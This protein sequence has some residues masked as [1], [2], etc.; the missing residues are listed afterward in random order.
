[1]DDTEVFQVFFPIAIEPPPRR[2]ALDAA[3]LLFIVKPNCPISCKDAIRAMLASW[4]ISLEELPWYLAGHFGKEAIQNAV[5]EL[6]QE[7]LSHGQK[8]RLDTVTYWS[9]IFFAL[10]PERLLEVEK[11]ALDE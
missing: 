8:V 1:M 7:A 6:S 11:R 2:G 9:N 4:D 5:E 3:C 10:P